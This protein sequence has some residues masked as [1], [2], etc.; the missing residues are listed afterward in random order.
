MRKLFKLNT[1]DSYNNA[2]LSNKNTS[3]VCF[4]THVL[5]GTLNPHAAKQHDDELDFINN[6]QNN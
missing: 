6:S 1:S 3:R 5:S 2:S 4:K